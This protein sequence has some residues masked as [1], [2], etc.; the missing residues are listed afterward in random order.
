M[1]P[2]SVSAFLVEFDCTDAYDIKYNMLN[3]PI[4]LILRF[5]KLGRLW[6]R[7]QYVR[8]K[9]NLIFVSTKIKMGSILISAKLRVIQEPPRGGAC[10]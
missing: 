1:R 5:L 8:A 4:L 7:P 6:N 10:H 9:K 3:V 2:I